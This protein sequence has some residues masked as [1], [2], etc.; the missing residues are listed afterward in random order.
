M[1]SGGITM[2]G[3]SRVESVRRLCE[4][5]VDCEVWL[6]RSPAIGEVDDVVRL[7][8]V[9]L[10]FLELEDRRTTDPLDVLHSAPPLASS[11]PV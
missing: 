3:D 8:Q 6:L 4:A 9:S 11:L 1:L 5:G 2:L 7:T 10:N